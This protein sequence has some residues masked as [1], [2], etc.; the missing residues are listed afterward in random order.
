MKTLI[1]LVL[2]AAVTAV[3]MIHSGCKSTAT[4]TETLSPPPPPSQENESTKPVP[5]AQ[6]KSSK[7]KLGAASSGRSR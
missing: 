6:P 1:L 2:F 5:A 3:A 4:K 7:A